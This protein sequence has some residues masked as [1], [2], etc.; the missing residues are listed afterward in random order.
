[1][2]IEEPKYTNLDNIKEKHT[3]ANVG[4]FENQVLLFDKFGKLLCIFTTA[5]FESAYGASPMPTYRGSN[6]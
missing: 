4:V 2:Y 5:E 1:M 3:I 6:E